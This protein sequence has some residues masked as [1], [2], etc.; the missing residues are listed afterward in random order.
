V[1]SLSSSRSD[2]SSLKALS[3]REWTVLVLAAAALPISHLL[4][5]AL[6]Y[7]R[8]RRLGERLS[9]RRSAPSDA[10][11]RATATT[12]LVWV[13]EDRVPGS[14]T[15]LS[16][17]L[18]LWYLLRNQGVA[19]DLRIGVRAGGAPLDAHAWVEH[20][21]RALNDDEGVADRFGTLER[22]SHSP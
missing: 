7:R 21:G 6:G 17:S 19:T 5:R 11:E 15:C 13:A 8:T 1:G 12:R 9:L 14:R 3:L 10:A 20:E 4:L 22:G 18:A 16:R 2:L